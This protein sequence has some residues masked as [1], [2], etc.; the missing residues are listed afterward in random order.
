MGCHLCRKVEQQ[1]LERQLASLTAAQL[2]FPV[3]TTVATVVQGVNGKPYVLS[4]P[5][6]SAGHFPR[7]G[8]QALARIKGIVRKIEGTS[9]RAV[10]DE[11][12]RL[13][14]LN[15]EPISTNDLWLN[16]NIQ[17]TRRVAKKY[18]VVKPEALLA[19]STLTD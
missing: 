2:E 11:I 17:W 13:K 8:W 1:E 3:Y 19:I 16:L 14:Q 10:F 15:E 18:Q 4:Q 5:L 7:N 9:A 6:V 12:M